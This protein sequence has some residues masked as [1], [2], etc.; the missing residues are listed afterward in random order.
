MALPKTKKI[1]II[2]FLAIGM[3][4]ILFVVMR[5]SNNF[6]FAAAPASAQ[7]RTSD[8]T[9]KDSDYDGLTDD[10]EISIYHTDPVLSDTDQDGYLDAAEV[11][12]GS[13]PIN[14]RD[15]ADFL[16]AKVSAP[17]LSSVPWY[18]V[19]SAAITAYLLMFFIIVL[20]TGMTTGIVYEK[21]SPPTAWS[22]HKYLS[23]SLGLTLLVHITSLLF[24]KFINFN[25]SDILIPFLSSYRPLF[26]ALGIIGF[27]T[28]LIIVISSLLMRL[29]FSFFWR[30]T[31]YATYPLFIF[32]FTHGVLTGTDT[33]TLPMQI[34]Y[35]STGFIFAILVI[36]RFIFYRRDR[37]I[38]K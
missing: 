8:L 16:S 15:P 3:I 12:S 11:L 36:Y 35:W 7:T 1:F 14:P 32:S 23:I 37:F 27:Y 34:I 13:D 24:D 25:I 10:A 6:L 26:V 18:I 33:K 19:R 29:K 31:H 17:A 5:E 2:S 20:G 28:M 38:K 21:I 9:E 22:I 30:V 4:F